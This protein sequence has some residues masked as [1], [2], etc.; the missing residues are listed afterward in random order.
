MNSA[1]AAPAQSSVC[2]YGRIDAGVAAGHAVAGHRAVGEG[3]P[4]EPEEEAEDEQSVGEG[5][6]GAVV[7]D[8]EREAETVEIGGDRAAVAARAVGADGAVGESGAAETEVVAQ[9]EQ[10]VGER[11]E[12]AVAVDVEDGERRRRDALCEHTVAVAVLGI[13]VS[14]GD[15]EITAAVGVDRAA[16]LTVRGPG[17]HLELG[18]EGAAR[19]AEAT[20]EDAPG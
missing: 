1:S 19:G 10:S 16:E 15:H 7:V 12:R 11:L 4:G 5:I 8:V 6:E 20:R 2:R 13:L 3:R 17:V 18:A 9:D 14:P